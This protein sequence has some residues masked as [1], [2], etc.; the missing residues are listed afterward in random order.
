MEETKQR[1]QWG[2]RLGF[3]LAA[4]GSAVGLGNIW[5]FPYITG[6]YGGSA[7]II[8]YLIA[9][10]LIGFPIMLAEFTIGRKAQKDAVGSFKSLA[11]DKPWYYTGYMGV[12]S[13]F[14]ILAFY[15]VVAGWTLAYIVESVT[16]KLGNV[17][18]D[19]LGD[20][21]GGFISNPYT[22]IF[23]QALFMLLTV[24]IVL[25]GVAKGIER[26]N[27][28]LMPTLVLLLVI[29]IIR[30]V[31]LPGA[32][33]GL[34]FLLKP[35]FSKLTATSLLVAIGHAFFSLSLGMG[36]MITYGGYLSKEDKLPGAAINV[37]IADT[38]IALMAGFAIFPAVFAFHM[39]PSAGPG[40]VFITLPAVFQQLPMG[41][42]FSTLFF[43]LLAIAALTS[44]ISILE[45]PVAFLHENFGWGRKKATWFIGTIIFLVG[46]PA[47]LSMG[48]WSGFKIAGMGFFDQLDFLSSYI[49]LPLGGFFISLFVAYA[50]K[51]KDA[52]ES[53]DFTERSGLG[54]FWITSLKYISPILILIV[55]VYQIYSKFFAG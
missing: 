33:A 26:W 45:V 29:I 28:I 25:G 12:A 35:D 47:S 55:F 48:S 34:E 8:V 32:G 20:H 6:E 4:A 53:A 2:S 24:L 44:S 22:P 9:I 16:G 11:P 10:A 27:K 52:L 38:L 31:T 17:T 54:A 13:A 42:F 1:E 41:A 46:I 19:K 43:L 36:T 5:K 7:F 49:L 15:G 51:K 21:F 37:S 30:S 14:M 23:W 50:M 40:L 39:D 3:I 18:P